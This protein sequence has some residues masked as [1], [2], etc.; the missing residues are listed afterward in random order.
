[1]SSPCSSVLKD[2]VSTNVTSAN[3]SVLGDAN[4]P[5]PTAKPTFPVR[6]NTDIYAKRAMPDL[7]AFQT[8]NVL[9][10]AHDNG[11]DKVDGPIA[12]LP[13]LHL[14]QNPKLRA[15]RIR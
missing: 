11:L 15:R 4:L 7:A 3:I 9:E 2:T 10:L 5:S 1:M 6:K 13:T 12:P 14:F 8:E